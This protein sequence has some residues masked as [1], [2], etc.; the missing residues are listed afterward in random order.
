MYRHLNLIVV[1]IFFILSVSRVHCPVLLNG[2]TL[3]GRCK[4]FLLLRRPARSDDRHFETRSLLTQTHAPD[5]PEYNVMLYVIEAYFDV[6]DL[7]QLS[8]MPGAMYR[9]SCHRAKRRSTR[10]R[11][12]GMW[13][14]SGD[15]LTEKTY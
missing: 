9:A 13:F 5:M 11:A 15:H 2:Q 12:P 14:G 4:P 10:S 7:D 3:A 8:W 6:P 1:V